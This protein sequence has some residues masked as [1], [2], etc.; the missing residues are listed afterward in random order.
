[1]HFFFDTET[2][3]ILGRRL[4]IDREVRREGRPCV[5]LCRGHSRPE[6]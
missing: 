4:A 5:L 1:M 6:E 3:F 2:D